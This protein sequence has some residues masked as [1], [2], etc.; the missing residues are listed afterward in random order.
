MQSYLMHFINLLLLD[1]RF[2]QNDT[3]FILLIHFHFVEIRRL[4]ISDFSGV[5]YVSIIKKNI[6][7]DSPRCYKDYD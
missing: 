3:S 7:V 2:F 1:T 5:F 6:E 4:L